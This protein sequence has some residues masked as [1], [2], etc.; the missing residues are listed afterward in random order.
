M[1]EYPAFSIVGEEWSTNPLIAAYWQEG[2]LN[3]SGYN[4]CLKSTMDFPMQ[5]TLV[6]ALT[7]T[8]AWDK[9]LVK[10]YEGLANDFV[11]ANP[12]NL[13]V[14]GDNHDMDRLFTFLKKDVDLMQMALSYLLTIRGFPRFIMA[15]RSCSKIA[16][17][18]VI[19]D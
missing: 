8:E 15:Q 1:N 9:G 11:Y 4:G 18:R 16:Q 7:E 10:L 19:M 12:E 14:F 6:Q 2:K 17:S 13:L 3:N 5:A